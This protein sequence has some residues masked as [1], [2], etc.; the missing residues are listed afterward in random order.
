LDGFNKYLRTK[1]N[2]SV[3]DVN[4]VFLGPNHQYNELCYSEALRKVSGSN[5]M[6]ML[7][8][9]YGREQFQNVILKNLGHALLDDKPSVHAT[10]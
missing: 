3:I 5:R 7:W 2:V 10:L 1:A 8:N 6:V 9:D 4:K